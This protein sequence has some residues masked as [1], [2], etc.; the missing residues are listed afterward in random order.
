MI[1]I[2][3]VARVSEE[4][5]DIALPSVAASALIFARR[6]LRVPFPLCLSS[7][8]LSLSLAHFLF[9][10]ELGFS[11]RQREGAGLP[12]QPQQRTWPLCE[13]GRCRAR[14]RMMAFASFRTARLARSLG[15]EVL[16][17]W[18]QR[19][20]HFNTTG[21]PTDPTGTTGFVVKPF[22]SWGCT[23]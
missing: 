13:R 11:S 4:A 21:R 6:A 18:R 16:P 15:R 10:A 22:E 7:L 1:R 14:A 23:K 8:S 20:L 12:R 5:R 19:L 2:I 3:N 9:W 17:F